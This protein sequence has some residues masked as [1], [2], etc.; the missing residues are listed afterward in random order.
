MAAAE[1]SK[2]EKNEERNRIGRQSSAVDTVMQD[3]HWTQWPQRSACWSNRWEIGKNVS[4]RDTRM[5]DRLQWLTAHHAGSITQ[6]MFVIYL[7][8]WNAN[9]WS[10]CFDKNTQ[11]RS[12]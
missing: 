8:E 1:A 5:I 7:Q 4:W 11:C 10:L 6:Y 12:A 3:Q 9:I 2:E